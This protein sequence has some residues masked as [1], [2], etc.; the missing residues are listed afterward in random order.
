MTKKTIRNE[1]YSEKQGTLFMAFEL[2]L[3]DWKLGF[4]IGLGQRAR[5]RSIP[6]GDLERLEREIGAAKNRFKLAE[7]S[8]MVSCYEAGRDGFWLVDREHGG[9]LESRRDKD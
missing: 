8:E 2:G 4:T 1:N 9:D 6:A 7:T 5:R 3:K